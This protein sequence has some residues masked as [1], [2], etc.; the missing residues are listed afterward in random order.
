M[1]GVLQKSGTKARRASFTG[2]AHRVVG[3]PF[4]GWS[5]SAEIIS[6]LKAVVLSTIIIEAGT[7]H[8]FGIR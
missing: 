8:R 3:Q 1:V 6:R 2:L 4:Y 7:D 5:I